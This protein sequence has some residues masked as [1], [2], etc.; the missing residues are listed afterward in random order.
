MTESTAAP[1]FSTPCYAREAS[2]SPVSMR[3]VV[4]QDA[5]PAPPPRGHPG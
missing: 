1:L 4:A 3:F 5:A 2:A